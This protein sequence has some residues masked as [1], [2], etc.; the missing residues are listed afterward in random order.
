MS[1]TDPRGKVCERKKKGTGTWHRENFKINH[2]RWCNWCTC[3]RIIESFWPGSGTA[4]D[5]IR[6]AHKWNYWLPNRILL[7]YSI[8]I[9]LVPNN[10]IEREQFQCFKCNNISC[11]KN[12]IW[13]TFHSYP[14]FLKNLQNKSSNVIINSISI[15][16]SRLRL[17]TCLFKKRRSV[18]LVRIVL[19]VEHVLA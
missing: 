17:A 11:C 7:I 6:I 9:V 16:W 8:F 1:I 2:P 5:A 12:K 10:S 14:E 3:D 15:S 19:T 18:A 13:S 4:L